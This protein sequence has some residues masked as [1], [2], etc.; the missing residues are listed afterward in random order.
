M[1][2]PLLRQALALVINL[3]SGAATSEDAA[4]LALWRQRSSAHEAAFRDATKLWSTFGAAAQQFAVRPDLV[5][6]AAAA[7][8]ARQISRRAW[9][10]G[11]AGAAAASVAVG[12]LATHPPLDLW[13]SLREL[14]ADLRT[15]KGE[16]RNV[17][18]SEDVALVLNT[19]T[20][21]AI[22]GAAHLE[23]LAGETSVQAT[24]EGPD[25]LVVEIGIGQ[26]IAHR[27]KFNLKYIDG[28]TT[29]T[30]IDGNVEV[31]CKDQR[32]R[33]AEREAVSYSPA[34]GQVSHLRADL[35]QTQAWQ[36]GLLIVR[37]WP[38]GRLVEEINRY[39]PG[40]III[41]DAELGRRMVSG[42]FHLDSLDD[43]ISQ[44]RGLFGATA[45]TLPG[46]IVLLS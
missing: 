32:V 1:P 20:S 45:R 39:R 3:H 21:I 27:A 41:V 5:L 22:R 2:D 4:E 11:I 26:A 43:V 28:V 19:Q 42:T 6:D 40:R 38:L 13:P 31:R 35:E 36:N 10:V 9:M 24:R 33:I 8:S 25:P 44:T 23:L 30:C 37:D 12:G 17:A 34:T 14:T 15:A 7:R 46:G 18:L 29:V 16:R